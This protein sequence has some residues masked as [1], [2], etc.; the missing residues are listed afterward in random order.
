MTPPPTP[1]GPPFRVGFV[2][3]VMPD[4]WGRVWPDLVPER[5]LEL[6][7]VDDEDAPDLLRSGGLH[8]CVLR[9]PVGGED[10]H[11]VRLYDEQPVV[12]VSRDHP[13]AVFDEVDV[14]DLADEPRPDADRAAGGVRRAVEAVAA[15]EGVLVVPMSLARLHHR[16]D[17]VAVPVTGVDPSTVALV[18]LR[19]ADD[20]LTQTFVG[21]V[22]GRRG[23]S[24]R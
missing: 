20:R 2:P 3:G 16:R 17:V 13:V 24:S 9:L 19:A 21:V 15:E 10:L 1:S 6:V 14:S 4:R 22:R 7:P 5:R 23:N 12:V 11:V 18:W 8:M